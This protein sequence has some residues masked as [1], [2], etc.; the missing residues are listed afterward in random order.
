M[1]TAICSPLLEATV[2]NPAD[3]RCHPQVKSHSPRTAQVVLKEISSAVNLHWLMTQSIDSKHVENDPSTG[4]QT[5]EPKD[6]SYNVFF[7]C[8]IE[9]GDSD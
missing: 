4:H 2:P 3:A 1:D 9:L 6:F 5:C 8:L 7:I